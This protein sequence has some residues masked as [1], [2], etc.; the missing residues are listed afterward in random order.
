MCVSVI[1]VEIVKLNFQ[2]KG[3]PLLNI[4]YDWLIANINQHKQSKAKQK[5]QSSDEP[6]ISRRNS[7][8]IQ[9]K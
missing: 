8:I 5:E 9:N 2:L 1:R 7:A 4:F 3:W 6:V